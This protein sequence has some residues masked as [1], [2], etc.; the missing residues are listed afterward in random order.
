MSTTR[1]RGAPLAPSY[2]GLVA[3]TVTGILWGTIGVLVRLLSDGGMT[4]QSIAFWR[5]ACAAAVLVP[6]LGRERLRVSAARLRHP[7][8]LVAV[9]VSSLLFQ[10]TYFFAV[11]DVGAGVATLISLG[12][13]PVVLHVTES[14]SARAAPA[15]RTLGVLLLALGG[16]VLV[17]TGDVTAQVA[18][19]PTLGLVE[20]VC[21]GLA[22]ALSTMWSRPLLTRLPPLSLTFVSTAVGMVLLLPVVA[23]TGWHVPRVPV[24]LAQ[25][26]WLG[27]VTSVVAYG[28]FYSGLHSTPGSTAMV[29]TL[30]EP[31]TAVVLAGLVLGEPTTA[32]VV[33]G[34]A[35]L[36]TAVA[37]LYLR[38]RRRTTP[39]D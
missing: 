9:A 11:R 15:P 25:V 30:L 6:V 22:F 23:W 36:L 14:V 4:P 27:V 38:P 34:G 20:A 8:R 10:L 32:H 31:V 37:A 5:Y 3:L 21:S 12:L 13:G 24:A 18:P 1:D 28:L 17:T 16:L 26:A 7:G 19:R 2:R 35:L 39:A 33:V 29:V